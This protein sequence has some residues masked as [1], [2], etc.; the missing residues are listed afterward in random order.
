[1]KNEFQYFVYIITNSYDTTLYIGMTNNLERRMLEHKQGKIEGF[2]K[3]YHLTKLV[4]YE[5]TDDVGAAIEREKQ[6]KNWHRDWKMNLIKE[7]NP[8]FE[9]LAAEWYDKES[10]EDD[11][12]AET[13]SHRA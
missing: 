6:L 3:R 8:K 10:F 5:E 13:S 1:M 2:S 7:S 9:D 4:Y 11:G 12:D